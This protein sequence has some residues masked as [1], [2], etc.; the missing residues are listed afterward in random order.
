[1]MLPECTHCQRTSPAP[2]AFL[3]GLRS[4]GLAL[5][6]PL[7]ASLQCHHGQAGATISYQVPEAQL[8]LAHPA[9]A[10]GE[11]LAISHEDGADGAG[12]VVRFGFLLRRR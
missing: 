4:V 10:R 12:A 1:M 6:H 7:G 9:E 2:R 8:P 11:D 5:A 3:A